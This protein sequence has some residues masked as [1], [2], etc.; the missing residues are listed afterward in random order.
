MS[1]P[2]PPPTLDDVVKELRRLDKK[3][4]KALTRVDRAEARSRPGSRG[5]RRPV[6]ERLTRLEERVSDLEDQA[7][8]PTP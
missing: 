6:L 5:P 8:P 1:Q 3:V 2:D 7:D 4:D